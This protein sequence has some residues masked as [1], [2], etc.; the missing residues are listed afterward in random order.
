MA[1]TLEE[2]KDFKVVTLGDLLE[3]DARAGAAVG[4]VVDDR[5]RKWAFVS[6]VAAALFAVMFVV[7]LAT[8]GG[9]DGGGGSSAKAKSIEAPAGTSPFPLTVGTNALPNPEVGQKYS[10]RADG[11]LLAPAASLISLKETKVGSFPQLEISL[12][13]TDAELASVSAV[14][15]K[16]LTFAGAVSQPAAT[17]T[18]PPAEAPAAPQPEAPVPVDPAAPAP[19]PAEPAPAAPPGA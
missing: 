14:D 6:T 4:G 11:E 1:L 2:A 16:D 17:D 13:L 18:A 10:I 9:D 7:A 3:V 8:G 12:A 15:K 5:Y 19:A